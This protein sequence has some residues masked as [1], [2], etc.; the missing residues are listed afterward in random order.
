[1]NKDV[2]NFIISVDTTRL[3]EKLLSVTPGDFISYEDLSNEI[4]RNVREEARGQLNYARTKILNE[5]RVD[6]VPLPGKGLRRLTDA[7]V[8]NSGLKHLR[9]V[10]NAARRGGR[11][12]GAIQDFNAL[13]NEDKIKHTSALAALGAMEH[14]AREKP[15][16]LIEQ[17][18]MNT[19]LPPTVAGTL[20]YFKK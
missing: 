20:D 5:S 9:R 19:G 12:M 16:K 8:A 7:E 17:H 18:I 2:G 3:V 1:M 11:H 13:A 6:F 4:G 14:M 10:R 15:L